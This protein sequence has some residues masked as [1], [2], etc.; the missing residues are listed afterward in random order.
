MPNNITSIVQ[1]G[2]DAFTNLY[3]IR[4]YGPS[5]SDDGTIGPTSYDTLFI[6]ESRIA[7]FTPPEETVEDYEVSYMMVRVK[8]LKPKLKIEKS[9]Q[10]PIRVSKDYREYNKLVAW[11]KY[12]ADLEGEGGWRESGPQNTESIGI[13]RIEVH[14]FRSDLENEEPVASWIFEDVMCSQVGQPQYSR[15]GSEVISVQSQFIFTR[16]REVTTGSTFNK[17]SIP[18][19]T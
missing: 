15:D 8:K 9:L 2:V 4:I 18:T 5:V 3:E 10:I 19:L 7:D 17:T 12:F 16:M 11:K 13:G 14:A 1:A 6:P